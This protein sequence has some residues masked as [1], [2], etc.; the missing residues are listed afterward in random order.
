[1]DSAFFCLPPKSKTSSS[2]NSRLQ[3]RCGTWAGVPIQDTLPQ[4]VLGPETVSSALSSAH[5]REEKVG[6]REGWEVV[7]PADGTHGR[8]QRQQP[9]ERLPDSRPGQIQAGP[10]QP[11]SEPWLFCVRHSDKCPH[12]SKAQKP[13]GQMFWTSSKI[14]SLS[15]LVSWT[16][17]PHAWQT[18]KQRGICHYEDKA[19]H[20]ENLFLQ[21]PKVWFQITIKIL[22]INDLQGNHNSKD[23]EHKH[24]WKP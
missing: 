16:Y 8:L 12:F 11:S 9:E 3:G 4:Q 19:E 22:L 20:L 14:L 7:G 17:P 15:L 2:R 6:K 13:R 5:C 23:S 1:M 18:G 24:L 10:L 21:I